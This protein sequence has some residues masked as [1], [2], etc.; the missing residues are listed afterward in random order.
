MW[1]GLRI[2]FAWLLQALKI[3]FDEQLHAPLATGPGAHLVVFNPLRQYLRRN[4]H[5][6]GLTIES[7]GKCLGV[8]RAFQQTNKRAPGRK[9]NERI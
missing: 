4:H 6:N 8:E 2:L 5:A 7:G 9:L 1:V 3:L